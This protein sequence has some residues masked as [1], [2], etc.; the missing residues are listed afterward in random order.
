MVSMAKK[1]RIL[2]SIILTI[3]VLLIF[4]LVRAFVIHKYKFDIVIVGND[5]VTMEVGSEYNE[6]SF[7]FNPKRDDLIDYVKI[8]NDINTNKVGEYEVNYTLDLNNKKIKKA[9]KVL[10]QDTTPP[11]LKIDSS[12][13]VYTVVNSEL[14]YPSCTATDNYD[15]DISDK[16]KI[17]SDV[18]YKTVGIY[19]ATYKVEDSS[20]NLTEENINIHVER[21]KKAYIEVAIKKQKLYYYEFDKLVL[22]SDVVTGIYDKTPYGTFSVINKARNVI[23]RGIN[24][25]SFVEYWIDFK[26]HTFGF[27]DASWRSKFGGEIYLNNGS[28]GCVNMPKDK[29]SKLYNVVA[30]GTPVYI[31]S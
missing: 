5:I 2:A 28:H 22:E 13:D 26:D 10:V 11:I 18:D 20:G 16:V 17:T 7:I 12:K 27:H 14:L 3:I 15:G 21:T 30:I 23:L 1:T 4:I 9:R 25:S 29:I 19:V 24:Y 6:L 8:T 31:H